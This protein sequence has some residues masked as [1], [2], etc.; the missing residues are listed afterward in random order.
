MFE[1]QNYLVGPSTND[2]AQESS[3][4]KIYAHWD[5]PRVQISPRWY[6]CF[7]SCPIPRTNI[8]FSRAFGNSIYLLKDGQTPISR[9]VVY[10][11]LQ[12]DALK[13]LDGAEARARARWS[14]PSWVHAWHFRPATATVQVRRYFMLILTI[15]SPSPS[16]R[17]KAPQNILWGNSSY[18]WLRSLTILPV[19]PQ[20]QA[21]P[22][23]IAFCQEFR[24]NPNCPIEN[25]ADKA[26]ET[27]NRTMHH[28]SESFFSLTLYSSSLT[29]FLAIEISFHGGLE[30]LASAASLIVGQGSPKSGMKLLKGAR[31]PFWGM[32]YLACFVPF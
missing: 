12:K 18:L 7:S 32:G 8:L 14:W 29:L 13:C 17:S 10:N 6:P 4:S 20:R 3:W 16:G 26:D 15:N 9:G 5:G 30:L 19:D 31:M 22:S 27:R 21:N 24:P 23:T 25:E 11:I 1:V 28:W 2:V